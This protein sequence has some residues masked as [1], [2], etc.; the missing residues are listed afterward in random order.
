VWILA[1]RLPEPEGPGPSRRVA[2]LIARSSGREGDRSGRR[3]DPGSEPS[4]S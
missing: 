4:L 1:P 3:M 2:G